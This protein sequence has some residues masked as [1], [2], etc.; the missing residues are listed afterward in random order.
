MST[1]QNQHHDLAQPKGPKLLLRASVRAES[2]VRRLCLTLE[3][4]APAIT[5]APPPAAEGNQPTEEITNLSGNLRPVTAVP[6]PC[7]ASASS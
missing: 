7:L 1:W 5:R 2:E 3:L 4:V 6:E